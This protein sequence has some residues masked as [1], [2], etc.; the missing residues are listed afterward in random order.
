M[1]CCLVSAP[2]NF[3]RTII[4]SA[5]SANLFATDPEKELRTCLAT[6]SV[7]N[8]MASP[9]GFNSKRISSLPKGRSSSTAIRPGTPLSCF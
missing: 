6:S 9:S 8:P 7:E 5:S 1:V 2:G 3:T 4:S